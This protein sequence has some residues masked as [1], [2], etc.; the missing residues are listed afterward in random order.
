MSPID[1][2]KILKRALR[3]IGESHSHH[4]AIARLALMDATGV[5]PWGER[6]REEVKYD[7]Y[8]DL[9]IPAETRFEKFQE[10]LWAHEICFND[11]K[12]VKTKENARNRGRSA[13]AILGELVMRF[14]G[15]RDKP[16]KKNGT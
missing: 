1:Q 10:E 13:E 3:R 2:L 8:R 15:W 9:T 5:H 12:P 16:E 7:G 14:M 4:G 6:D 11:C